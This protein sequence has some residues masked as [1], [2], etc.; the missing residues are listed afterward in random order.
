M[1]AADIQLPARV[2]QRCRI[3]FGE[4]RNDGNILPA[5]RGSAAQGNAGH[6]RALPETGA[7]A[8]A[9]G[10]VS[11]HTGNAAAADALV[12]ARQAYAHGRRA[13]VA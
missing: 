1:E 5:D 10:S 3:T 12:E 9:I 8:L 2:V 11:R 7:A 4:L 13:T 6:G